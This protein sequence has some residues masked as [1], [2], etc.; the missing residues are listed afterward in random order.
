MTSQAEEL[1]GI[2][3]AVSK[4][5]GHNIPLSE[6]EFLQIF[7]EVLMECTSNHNLCL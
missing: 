1:A 6:L 7:Y 2:V 3:D 5:T 4:A